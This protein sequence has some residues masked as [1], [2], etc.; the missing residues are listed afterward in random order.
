MTSILRSR[1]EGE[2]RWF[3]PVDGDWVRTARRSAWSL[4][5]GWQAESDLG[6][7]FPEPLGLLEVRHVGGMLE[8]HE[9][10]ARRL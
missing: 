1:G 4:C 3:G 2:R 5:I 10:F 7:Q 9:L 8:P 6:E